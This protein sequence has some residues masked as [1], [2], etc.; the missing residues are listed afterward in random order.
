MNHHDVMMVKHFKHRFPI[1]VPSSED[2]HSSPPGFSLT[3]PIVRG[4]L[5]KISGPLSAR[6]LEEET[7]SET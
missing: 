6:L 1:I 4:F 5:G 7:Y 3:D 2:P